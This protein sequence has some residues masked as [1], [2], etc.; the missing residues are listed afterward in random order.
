MKRAA[1]VFELALEDDKNI[2]LF[3]DFHRKL[4]PGG[5]GE[6]LEQIVDL[7]SDT[8]NGLRLLAAC[9]VY[10]IDQPDTEANLEDWLAEYVGDDEK[11]QE[12]LFRYM[13]TEIAGWDPRTMGRMEPCD[14]EEFII[15]YFMETLDAMGFEYDEDAL[16]E[17]LEGYKTLDVKKLPKLSSIAG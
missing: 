6:Q 12:K 16:T 4:R 11:K 2:P 10:A 8:D 1:E 14:V 13:L 17:L 9:C 5:G 3:I 15:P 7:L